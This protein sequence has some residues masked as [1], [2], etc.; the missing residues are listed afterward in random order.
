M[1]F[2]IRLLDDDC[3]QSSGFLAASSSSVPEQQQQQ[4][5]Q[6]QQH[7]QCPLFPRRQTKRLVDRGASIVA[8]DYAEQEALAQHQIRF[9]RDTA[10][11]RLSEFRFVMPN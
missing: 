1:G 8:L 4:Q 10:K 7:R 2:V 11:K 5:Q 6:Q 9:R 3:N